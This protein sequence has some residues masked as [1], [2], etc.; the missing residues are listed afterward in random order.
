MICGLGSDIVEIAR[1]ERSCVRFG[2]RFVQKILS[3]QEIDNLQCSSSNLKAHKIAARFA[4]KEAAVKAL[5]TG[6]SQGITWHDISIINLP[7][8]QPQLFFHANALKKFHEL[9]AT[10]SHISLSHERG[11]AHA[12]VILEKI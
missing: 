10:C 6:F 1:I 2:M 8:G 9:G 7:S 3:P 12:V 4:A 11:L 5:G